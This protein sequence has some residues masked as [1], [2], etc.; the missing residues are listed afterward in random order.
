MRPR[1]RSALWCLPLIVGVLPAACIPGD[2]LLGVVGVKQVGDQLLI[3]V[4]TCYPTEPKTSV[5]LET[6]GKQPG[7]LWEIDSDSG[8]SSESYVAGVTPV[9]FIERV[10]LV[11]ALRP[12]KTYLVS[13]GLRN[14]RGQPSVTFR[15]DRLSSDAFIVTTGK[16]VKDG[17]FGK[18][19]PCGL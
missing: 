4:R 7:L 16:T 11:D 2:P 14:T 8:S 18:L 6:L 12:D 3:R 5:S 17:E 9:G 1:L 10:P 15:A 19:D 13:V